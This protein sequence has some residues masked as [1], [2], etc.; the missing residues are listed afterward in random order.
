MK[1]IS[2]PN[3]VFALTLVLAIL[4]SSSAALAAPPNGVD[5]LRGRWD[6]TLYGLFGED[7]SFTLLLDESQPDPNDSQAALYNG[8]MTVGNHGQYAPVSARVIMLGNEQYDLTLFGTAGGAVIKLTGLIETHGASVR[9]D[10]AGGTWQTSSEEGDW[11]ALHHDRRNPKCPDVQLGDGLFFGGDVYGVVGI[12]PDESRNEG[13]ILEGFSN[14]VSS[15]MRVTL[16]N[17][18]TV[19]APLFTDLFSPTVDFIDS[20][21][22]LTDFGGLPVSGGTYSFTLL[23]VFGQPIPGASNTDVWFAC[24]MDAPRNVSAVVDV[25]GI[26]VKWDAVTPADG[27]DPSNFIGFYQIELGP[28]TGDGNYGANDIHVPAHLIPA[29][30][31]GGFATGTPDGNDFGNALEELSEGTYQFSVIS[32]SVGFGTGASG[33][34]CQIRANDELIRFEKSGET[35]TVLR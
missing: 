31:F 5:H 24:A 11:S 9:D 19:V 20:F 28:E 2:Y 8:C 22:F 33:L 34:E 17:G 27:F 32:F 1:R 15:G 3:V 12:N 23:D 14:I 4:G 13:T 26:H 7:Q 30:S 6:G 16:P 35:I 29:T 18:D 10:S 21:R 25:D